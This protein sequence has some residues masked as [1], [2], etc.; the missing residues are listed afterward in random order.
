MTYQNQQGQASCKLCDS[1]C[2]SCDAV[3]G[4]CLE[5]DPGYGYNK[6][7][8]PQTCIA[9]TDGKFSTG[10][11]N[12]CEDCDEDC[13]GKCLKTSNNCTA[14]VDGKKLVGTCKS[15]ADFGD[16][17]TCDTTNLDQK[18]WTCKQCNQGDYLDIENNECIA[19]EE[20]THIISDLSR[21]LMN[22]KSK[23]DS[24][25]VICQFFCSFVS[26]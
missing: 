14:C 16:C 21:V 2:A 22:K 18:E 7:A 10:G 8:T 23:R 5:C 6:D 26:Y 13:N 3:T 20:I 9:C 12:T 17:F 25:M 24:F 11:T 19:C 4:K 15:C 1:F